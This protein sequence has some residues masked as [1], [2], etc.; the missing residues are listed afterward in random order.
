MVTDVANEDCESEKSL[1]QPLRG[2]IF[3]RIWLASLLSNLGQLIQGVGAAWEM[4][5]LAD[6]VEMVALVQTAIMLPMM[7]MSLPAG[8]MAD[9]FDRRKI[10]LAGL[11]FACVS[12]MGLTVMAGC[13]WI[14]PWS[15]LLFCFLIGVGVT[16]Y[17]PAWQ[18]SIGEQVKPVHLASAIA[19]GSIS[20]NVARSFGPAIGGVVVATMGSVAAFGINALFYVPLMIAFLLWDRKPIP[21]RLPPEPISRAII[22]GIRYAYHSPPI[23]T[24][25]TRSF[26]CGLTGASI[27][28]LT[29]LVAREL[30]GGTA[31]TYGILLG[32]YGVGAVGGAFA[33]GR[34]SASRNLESVVRTLSIAN[35]AAIAV[36][37]LSGQMWLTGFAMLVGGAVWMLI[38]A[39]LNVSV[40]TS[41]PRWVT[42]RAVSCFSCALAGGV[43]LG[44]WGWGI[45]ANHIGTTDGL[46]ISGFAMAATIIV[47]FFNPLPNFR[48]R[49]DDPEAE[50]SEP[51]V[52]MNITSLSGP[53]VIEI[54]YRVGLSDARDF[55]SIMQKLRQRRLRTGG[56]GW[57]LSRDIA[58]PEIW[59]ES[60][61]C[62]TWGD[63]IRQRSRLTKDDVELQMQADAFHMGLHEGRVHR[64][65]E[66]PFGSVRFR[67]D[68]PDPGADT[69]TVFPP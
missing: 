43:A 1:L 9:M 8:A 46:V 53:I 64:R 45:I 30:L 59:V 38:V 31:S 27:A 68:T 49:H 57:T 44:A 18:A 51:D 67:A 54:L 56:F 47:G 21:S 2:E 28:A 33:I 5:K 55:Y 22:S 4:T 11:A 41:A 66:R 23:R 42:A 14:T 16:L 37:G 40:Q 65:L 25:L 10:A 48:D 60:Y 3:R 34:C 19:L 36:C 13:G 7:L 39:L 6:S 58:D 26:I 17:A 12:A 29:P 24:V 63:Y 52:K 32:I 20:Y 50:L 69:N 62:P 35:A 15:L 61:F